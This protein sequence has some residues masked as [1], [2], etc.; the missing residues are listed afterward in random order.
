M[1]N[2]LCKPLNVLEK[3]H[4]FLTIKLKLEYIF[5]SIKNIT[6]LHLGDIVKF[7]NKEYILIQ[8]VC[9]PFWDLLEMNTSEKN[10]LKNIHKNYFNT[11]FTLNNLRNR[12]WG[13]YNWKMN[14]W[15]SI[16][17]KDAINESGR[18][19]RNKKGKHSK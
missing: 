14:N 5:L 18:N 9:N 19:K 12:F 6:K 15:Y 16:E 10:V 13:T 1:S 8:G 17:L 4:P 3:E 7:N 11:E 2:N